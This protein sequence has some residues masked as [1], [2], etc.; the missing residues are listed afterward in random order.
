MF[1]EDAPD[2]PLK[3][4]QVFQ[5]S[6]VLSSMNKNS[7][8]FAMKLKKGLSCKKIK[9]TSTSSGSLLSSGCTSP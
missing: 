2:Q 7:R 6:Y 3:H 5:S 8:T 1:D 4:H 9:S